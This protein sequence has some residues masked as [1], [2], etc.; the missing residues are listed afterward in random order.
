[1]HASATESPVQFQEGCTSPAP[2][3]LSNVVLQ[4]FF[5]YLINNQKYYLRR[6]CF[7]AQY[8]C[9]S[10]LATASLG[11]LLGGLEKTNKIVHGCFRFHS[12]DCRTGVLFPIWALICILSRLLKTQSPSLD[13][14][15]RRFSPKLWERLRKKWQMGKNRLCLFSGFY[16]QV[17]P[18]LG[19]HCCLQIFYLSAAQPKTAP[20]FDGMRHSSLLFP[21]FPGSFSLLPLSW[22]TSPRPVTLGLGGTKD[23]SPG[24]AS[25]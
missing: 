10:D 1:M 5:Y 14:L 22:M 6:P 2:E 12:C 17:Y 18:F 13:A 9:W 8:V 23:Q 16:L 4:F 11:T 3:P 19:S 7:A 21:I 25:D 20:C 15:G 24:E